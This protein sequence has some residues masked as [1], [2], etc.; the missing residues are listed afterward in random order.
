MSQEVDSAEDEIARAVPPWTL[1]PQA[2]PT[3][4][5]QLQ[6]VVRQRRTQHVAD[7]ALQL[8]PLVRRHANPRV[9]IEAMSW[10]ARLHRFRAR[11]HSGAP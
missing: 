3:V 8:L 9:H 11:L 6:P 10:L 5:Q 2:N 7:Q 1:K 4:V